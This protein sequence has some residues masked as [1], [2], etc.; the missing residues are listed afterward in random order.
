MNIQ[1]LPRSFQMERTDVSGIKSGDELSDRRRVC[2]WAACTGYLAS[3]HGLYGT[4][5]WQ[6]RV[7][8]TWSVLKLSSVGEVARAKATEKI[9][10]RFPF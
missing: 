5:H 7:G 6:A 4:N 1:R 9:E 8:E 3:V 10:D 2:P